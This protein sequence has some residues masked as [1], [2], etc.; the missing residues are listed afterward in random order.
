MVLVEEHLITKIEKNRDKKSLKI[1]DKIPYGPNIK[2]LE[3]QARILNGIKKK[4]LK[5]HS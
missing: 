5:P 2:S 4:S 1:Q 3:F